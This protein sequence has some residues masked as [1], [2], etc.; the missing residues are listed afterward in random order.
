M[1]LISSASE[2]LFKAGAGPT[3]PPVSV[4]SVMFTTSPLTPFVPITCEN[5]ERRC[6]PS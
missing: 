6:D 1:I 5:L 4:L 3:T 2:Y